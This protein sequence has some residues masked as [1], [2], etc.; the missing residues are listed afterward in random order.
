M[1]EVESGLIIESMQVTTVSE[2]GVCRLQMDS[3]RRIK[4]H[5]D[6]SCILALSM[7]FRKLADFACVIGVA[8]RRNNG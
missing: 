2:A 4:S 7:K 1:H 6:A 8:G 3:V 5:L